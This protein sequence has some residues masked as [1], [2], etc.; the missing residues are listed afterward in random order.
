[1][2]CR[3]RTANVYS[4]KHNAK[5]IPVSKY[6]AS[7]FVFIY[8]DLYLYSGLQYYFLLAYAVD[9]GHLAFARTMTYESRTGPA[10]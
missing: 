5:A 1:M 2:L 9:W 7:Y 4:A 10:F 8:W 3:R 6:R